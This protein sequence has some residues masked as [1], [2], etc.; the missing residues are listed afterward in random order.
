MERYDE[1]AILQRKTRQLPASVG[2]CQ[3]CHI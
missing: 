3:E 2:A 1:G